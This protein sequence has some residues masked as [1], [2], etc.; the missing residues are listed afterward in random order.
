MSVLENITQ[1]IYPFNLNC[2]IY[3][4]IQNCSCMCLISQSCPTLVTPWISPPG[5]SS[6]GILQ[7]R[8]LEW[9][10]IPS[11]GDLPNP[12]I[13]PRSPT[14]QEDS[15]PAEPSVKPKSTGVGRLSLLQGIFPTQKSN[16]GL[17]HCRLY[18]LTGTSLIILLPSV[19]LSLFYF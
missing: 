8:I 11:P 18:Q 7:T 10:G 16:Q 9:E 2:Q 15:L 17:L 4:V 13:E 6:M 3:I 12:G 19:M 1:G 5:S 14:L